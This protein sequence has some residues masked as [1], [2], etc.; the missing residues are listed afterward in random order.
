MSRKT[1]TKKKKNE[2]EDEGDGGM[3]RWAGR[4]APLADTDRLGGGEEGEGGGVGNACA[5]N[6]SYHRS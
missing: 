6:E 5:P 4:R 1:K 2:D 3:R